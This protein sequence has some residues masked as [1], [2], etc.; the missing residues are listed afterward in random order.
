MM[1]ILKNRNVLQGVL[2][3]LSLLVLSCTKEDKISSIGDDG[4][5]V[6]E[7]TQK[8][9][10]FKVTVKDG[11]GTRAGID[12]MGKYVFR[13]GDRLFLESVHFPLQFTPTVHAVLS[14][15]QDSYGK[16][17]G[18]FSG[19]L[20]IEG[21]TD[22]SEE[23]VRQQV[24]TGQ[25][26]IKV[27]LVSPGDIHNLS[28]AGDLVNAVSPIQNYWESVNREVLTSD[29]DFKQK[30]LNPVVSALDKAV[31]KYGDFTG[32]LEYDLDGNA[33][34]ML[35]NNTSY[36]VF[37]VKFLDGTPAGK[38]VP[39]ALKN[40]DEN[41][42]EEPYLST[43]F[44][45][46]VNTI[47]V[48]N[49]DDVRAIFVLP[50]PEGY[51]MGGKKGNED[52]LALLEV[53]DVGEIDMGF[54]IKKLT[55]AAN[56]KYN[57]ERIV[58]CEFAIWNPNSK[59]ATVT[60]NYAELGDFA[61]CI[62]GDVTLVG[63]N[64]IDKISLDQAGWKTY[65]STEEISIQDP[66]SESSL[67]VGGIELKQNEIV[68]FRSKR[69]KS[70]FRDYTKNPKDPPMFS[71]SGLT[72]NQVCYI[73]GDIMYLKCT[74]S[75]TDY[76]RG[77][78]LTNKSEF[79][80]AFRNVK[81]LD[82]DPHRNLVLSATTL[83]P[84]CYADMF[85]GDSRTNYSHIQ[86]GSHIIIA[87]SKMAQSSCESMFKFSKLNSAPVI[88][89]TTLA[90]DCC[91][92]MFSDCQISV[93]PDLP[94]TTLAQG[95]YRQM[96]YQCYSI[97]EIPEDYLKATVME[98][99][100]YFSMFN[101]THITKAPKLISTSL[102]KSCYETMFGKC[103]DLTATPLLPATTLAETCYKGMFQDCTNL[104]TITC[105]ATDIS[106][107]NCTQDWVKNIAAG[108]TFYKN[109]L[110]SSWTTG[111]KGIPSGWSVSD[112]VAAQ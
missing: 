46:H 43:I 7:V 42:T 72:G 39:V 26:D 106:A 57:I 15:D 60:F 29:P 52:V 70:Y 76:I 28:T 31:S 96:F 30:N 56:K 83:T 101:G 16:S 14:L 81:N 85:R 109:S 10:P 44:S 8:K 67:V 13:A 107:T 9:F 3:L 112:Y 47:A 84:Y 41:Q 45:G 95:C 98:A 27:T 111:N 2:I 50:F 97:T 61:Q 65:L 20:I 5:D 38:T 51:N 48:E 86:N 54:T 49:D 11:V 32:N 63:Q 79:Q 90:K 24:Q 40:F 12:E 25:M 91:R 87:A 108:G 78:T 103:S 105:L 92:S 104:K 21:N 23:D 102:A 53:E 82:I 110:M 59:T 4:D 55:T 33:T 75:G 58:T 34:C 6:V 37:N 100:C 93:V 36:F 77:A 35:K 18:T 69:Q 89:A 66:E 74:G 17:Q 68:M 64:K 22:L 99:E 94:A 1:K 88:K 62:K 80:A 19:D 73:F 71:I